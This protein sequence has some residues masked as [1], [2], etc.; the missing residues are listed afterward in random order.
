[1]GAEGP[2]D[3]PAINNLRERQIRN[4]LATLLLSQGVP[5]IA[6]GDEFSRSQRGNNN[7][8][9]QDNELTW[10]DWKLDDS[11]VRLM[12]FTRK[13]VKLRRTHP[14]LHRHKFFQDREIRNSVVRDI[15]WYG[16]DGNEMPESA[17]TTEWTR[18]MGVML[19]GK[20]LQASNEDGDPLQD[21]SFLILVNAFHE[22]VEFKLPAVPNGS[23][24][25]YL[26]DTENIDDPFKSAAVL[27]EKVILGGRSMMV[28]SDGEVA[29]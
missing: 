13:L 22:G 23:P 28:F 16:A 6:G 1:M 5:M 8:Y 10:Y 24:W 19:N 4:F 29:G 3:D 25:R 26:M 18:S 11:R 14:N 12:E 17:W 27:G 21:D 9:C 2:T 7:G 15:A 20:T